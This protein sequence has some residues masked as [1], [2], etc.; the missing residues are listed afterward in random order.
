[1]SG[2]DMKR[3]YMLAAVAV[4]SLVLAPACSSTDGEQR[5][6]QTDASDGGYDADSGPSPD[7]D[8]SDDA[9][10]DADG[11][12]TCDV[13]AS[14]RARVDGD[15]EWTD[16]MLEVQP[17]DTIEFDAGESEGEVAEYRWELLDAPSDTTASLEGDGENAELTAD[18]SGTYEVE[19]KALGD[20]DDC[21]E[22][23]RT[24][25]E[26]CG[27][28]GLEEL[29]V[30]MSVASNEEADLELH[31]LDTAGE[32]NEEP[33]DIYPDHPTADWGQEGDESDDPMHDAAEGTVQNVNHAEVTD[34]EY[35]VGVHYAGDDQGAAFSTIRL[36][37][38]GSMEA[39][40]D[41]REL[42]AGQ[43]WH[44][45][46][47]NASTAEVEEVDEITDGVPDE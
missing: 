2:E 21:E 18:L 32:W 15:E 38:D 11:G 34:G 12:G 41:N 16:E 3:H 28:C 44:A 39:E 27:A 26:V 7:A 40:L 24:R 22:T 6:T 19:L 10:D 30:Q 14:L 9:G 4:V 35:A 1:M 8:A 46:T 5:D 25:I 37:Y 20:G 45:L 42:E 33:Y 36:F 31:Y 47:F 29:H 23:S 13:D 17:L 43:F